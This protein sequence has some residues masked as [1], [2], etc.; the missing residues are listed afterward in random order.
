MQNQKPKAPEF[1][2][3]NCNVKTQRQWR[4]LKRKQL[5]AVIR[6]MWEYRAGCAYCPG[7]N[8]EFGII[9]TNLEKLEKLL[10]QKNWGK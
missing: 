8:G 1:V 5:K 6:A 7:R 4:Q 2:L 10:S 9:T 3:R